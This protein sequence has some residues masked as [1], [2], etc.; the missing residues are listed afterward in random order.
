MAFGNLSPAGTAL[1]LGDMLKQQV[2]D[3]T[4]EERKRRMALQ[5]RG[6]SPA[7]NSI[8]NSFSNRSAGAGYGG[9]SMGGFWR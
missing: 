5:Q 8:L 2:G 3:E 6:T 7:T 9:T 4:D 1:G